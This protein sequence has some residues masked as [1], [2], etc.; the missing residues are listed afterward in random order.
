MSWKLAPS[1]LV[2]RNQVDAAYPKRS[3]KSD[4]TI[5]DAAHAKTRSDHNPNPQGIVCAL[6]LTNDPANGFDADKFAEAQRKNPHPN[7]KYIVWRGRI[8][9][10][11]HGWTWRPSSGHFNHIHISVG[12]GIDGRSLPGTYE[13]TS[14]WDLGQKGEKT[15]SADALTKDEFNY[16]HLLATGDFPGASY[17]GRFTG[18]PLTETLHQWLGTDPLKNPNTLAFKTKQGL[19]VKPSAATLDKEKLYNDQIEATKKVFGK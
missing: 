18:K 14:L 9:S 2:L 8:A 11:K 12:I 10:A 6:D 17:D 19:L 1:L 15:M 5:G 3:K 13:N 4:G 16:L 7:I